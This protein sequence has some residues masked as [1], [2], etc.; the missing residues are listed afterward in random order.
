MALN[1]P[2]KSRYISRCG[3]MVR[4][5]FRLSVWTVMAPWLSVRMPARPFLSL[6]LEDGSWNAWLPRMAFSAHTFQA[7]TSSSVQGTSAVTS[8][9]LEHHGFSTV[10]HRPPS[11]PRFRVQRLPV[12]PMHLPPRNQ[13][14]SPH[15]R[16]PVALRIQI[17]Q[18]PRRPHLLPML[19]RRQHDRPVL[20]RR[21][22]RIPFQ[23]RSD[24]RSERAPGRRDL[25]KVR[26]QHLSRCQRIWHRNMLVTRDLAWTW[27]AARLAYTSCRWR[28]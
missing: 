11:R 26:R 2:A 8:R 22:R 21:P 14:R 25:C 23:P 20:S 6:D 19:P 5:S 4:K 12:C 3:E 24:S 16:L 18:S 9:P 27:P 17:C 10:R 13:P 15:C 7:A 1:H 28:I